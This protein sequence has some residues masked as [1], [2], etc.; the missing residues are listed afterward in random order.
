MRER[1]WKIAYCN[2]TTFTSKTFLSVG[3]TS[4]TKE[5]VFVLDVFRLFNFTS[6]SA[7]SEIKGWQSLNARKRK[8]FARKITHR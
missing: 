3:F 5:I 1:K 7:E 4:F 8:Q 2:E 6:L